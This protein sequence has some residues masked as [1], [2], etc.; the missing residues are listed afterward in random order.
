MKISKNKKYKFLFPL[1]SCIL[2]ILIAIII[3]DILLRIFWDNSL[4][5]F[6]I[7]FIQN[8]IHTGTSLV[9]S[10]KGK[11][12][13]YLNY[14][15]ITSPKYIKKETNIQTNSDGMRDIERVGQKDNNSYRILSIG[16]SMVY[17]FGIEYD[18]MFIAKT[19]KKIS[20]P[21]GFKKIEI[22]KSAVPGWG[23]NNE[24]A[25]LTQNHLKYKPNMVLISFFVENDYWDS[26]VNSVFK[27]NNGVFTLKT[28]RVSD[29]K[30]LLMKYW[31]F[32]SLIQ[33]NL[34]IQDPIRNMYPDI[35]ALS[36]SLSGSP[37]PPTKGVLS[38]LIE[39]KKICD[40]NNYKLIVL[41][42]PHRIQVEK[43]LRTELSDAI[44]MD[45][46]DFD[47]HR[48]S[49]II[50]YI[51]S[52]LKIDNIDLT[53][54]LIEFGKNRQRISLSKNDWHYSAETND[55][56]SDYLSKQLN[57]RISILK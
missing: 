6:P 50:K 41:I 35:L 54:I 21:L 45:I 25:F 37:L 12:S 5:Y 3:I 24:S 16:D 42:L 48:L 19:E 28:N 17:G 8:D 2:G 47:N 44:S 30:M 38:S 20:P 46:S 53:G 14:S 31:F 55:K 57:K 27:V 51:L 32:Y 9:P 40:L 7:G 1:L 18:E 49:S 34:S 11:L 39:I 33:K 10:Q 23:T 22:I 4:S 52:N 29:T 15:D 26:E 13:L 56:I 36:Y 43:S